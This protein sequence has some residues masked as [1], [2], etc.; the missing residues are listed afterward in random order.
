MILCLLFTVLIWKSFWWVCCTLIRIRDPLQL[1]LCPS[2]SWSRLSSNYM[3]I[4]AQFLV[5][6]GICFSGHGILFFIQH[7]VVRH[8]Y[9]VQTV[10]SSYSLAIS[11]WNIHF[12]YQV[13]DLYCEMKIKTKNSAYKKWNENQDQ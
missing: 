11:Y 4:L 8:L 7:G 6:T 9:L 5:Q 3:L 12:L 10:L 13:L 1:K 2:H